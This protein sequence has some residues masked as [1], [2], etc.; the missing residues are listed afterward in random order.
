MIEYFPKPRT[1]GRNVKAELDLS[2]YATKYAKKVDLVHL[3]SEMDKLDIGKLE[4]TPV[5]LNKIVHIVKNE[6]TK[7]T[8]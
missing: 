8:V 7:K 5:D 6:V 2:D 3:K 1:L 4:T